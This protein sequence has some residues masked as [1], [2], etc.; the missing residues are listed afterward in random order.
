[1]RLVHDAHCNRNIGHCGHT[2][3]NT[4]TPPTTQRTLGLKA[5]PVSSLVTHHLLMRSTKLPL[6]LFPLP[7]DTIDKVQGPFHTICQ[8]LWRQTVLPVVKTSNRL[9]YD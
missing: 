9:I 7:Q 4:L 2:H 1:M 6:L 3:S 8:E 5:L